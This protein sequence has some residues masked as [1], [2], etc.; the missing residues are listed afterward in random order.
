MRMLVTISA[1]ALALAA[2]ARD[3]TT[4]NQE[5]AA[6]A[7]TVA[8]GE[9]KASADEAIAPA[10]AGDT[11]AAIRLYAFNCGHFDV[12]D[13]APFDRDGAYDGQEG[14]VADACFLVR[15]PNGDLLWDTGMPDAL[16]A[17]PD[18]MTNPPFH[19]TMPKTLK[20]QLAEIGLTPDDIE[21]LSL[22]HSHF[23]HVGNANDYAG[24][25]WLVEGAER[26][27]MF[28]DE[29]RANADSFSMYSALE[30]ADTV[31]FN[32]DWDVFGDGSVMIVST[33]G[34][35][36]GHA[37]LLV[38]LQNTGPVLLT[39]DLYHLAESRKNRRI[40]IFNTDAEET[41]R[42]M[43]KFEPLAASTGARVII[44]HEPD[45]FAEL[46]KVPAYLD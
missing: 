10:P 35:T 23:D 24:A 31:E 15:H 43:D 2:C 41:L 36:P 21:L 46:P 37:S 20:G 29:A 22:S 19:A 1:L 45:D 32:G 17:E 14:E 5:T 25:T 7:I 8:E 12:S 38:N 42:S 30:N 27:F 28:S 16:N 44:Q 40:P 3:E 9:A 33:P 13:M 26:S 6:S 34:H 39:G 11:E 4:E 18:G